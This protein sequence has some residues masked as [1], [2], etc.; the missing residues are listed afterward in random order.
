[1]RRTTGPD[2][3]ALVIIL[4]VHEVAEHLFVLCRGD[5]GE[6]F[7]ATGADHEENIE[8]LGAELVS[9][10]DH[11]R[12]FLVIHG[13]RAEVHLEGQPVP[14]AGLDTGECGFPRTGY[15]TEAIVFLR[16]ERIDADAH[17][18][19]ADLDQVFRHPVV[20]QH[21]VGAEHHHEA[22][23][24]GVAR[25]V[26]D[27]GTDERFAARDH[28]EAA[29]VDLGN[30]IDELIAFFCREFV[31]PAGGLRRRI[32]IAMVALEIAPL[33]EVQRDEIGFEIVDGSAV[34]WRRSR[35]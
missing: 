14:L 11:I 4:T 19:H 1:M 12:Q 24:H 18:H 5:V 31:V 15:A 3:H 22:E 13:L 9:P 25:D 8:D 6:F 2:E 33:R 32:E 21:A 30:L 7:A 34:V 17:T 27:V 20:D 23:F 28:E 26:E 16:I 10:I 29:L 35:G